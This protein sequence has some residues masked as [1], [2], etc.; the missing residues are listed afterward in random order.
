MAGRADILAGSAFVRL[1]L[2]DD[3]TNN[4]K[5]T[6]ST[7]ATAVAPAVAAVAAA[8]AAAAAAVKQ[9]TDFGS[10]INDMSM[11]T[12][13][14]TTQLQEW[15]FAA[16]QTGASADDLEK[17]LRAAAK[18]GVGPGDFE[19]VGME[20]ASIPDPAERAASAMETF[21]KSGTKLIPM[22]ADLNNLKASSRALGPLLS[23]DEVKAADALGDAF[24]ALIET[25]K[26]MTMQVG[27]ALGP[28]LIKPIQTA[29]GIITSL[30]DAVTGEGTQFS[31]DLLDRL[32]QF[33]RMSMSEFTARGAEGT[34]AFAGLRAAGAAGEGEERRAAG[35]EKQFDITR[36]II[37][38]EKERR[39]LVDEF[40]TPQER[41]LKKLQ[42]FSAALT[43]VNK[44]RVLGFIS[45]QQA[46]AERAA[47]E[48]AQRRFLAQE[49]QKN[50]KPGKPDATG[51]AGPSIEAKTV[52]TFSAFGAM[53]LA[54]SAGK[55][56]A[57]LVAEHAKD[58]KL[59]ERQ[60]K[61]QEE[62]VRKLGP[63]AIAT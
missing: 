1:F 54:T 56:Q 7:V 47:L 19:R 14:N 6:I 48:Q 17:A 59:L 27:A 30:H 62:M 53:A 22:F 51:L 20:I 21:G 55:G 50:F 58:R 24:G 43:Q 61:L 63:R 44:N 26:R 5:R 18:N 8:G 11:R 37:D 49:A 42:E 32:A 45:P 52:S 4:L 13:A 10:A 60:I 33:R 28:H 34:G 3:L 40:A 57:A 23:P 12:G 16:E 15:T 41:M 29:I 31:G 46:A 36:S 35:L 38:A 9:F 2:K 25:I 39:R